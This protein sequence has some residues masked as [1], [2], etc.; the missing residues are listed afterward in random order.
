[1]AR[2]SISVV[3]Q[4][5]QGRLDANPLCLQ[6]FFMARCLRRWL[7]GGTAVLTLAACDAAQRVDTAE[8]VRPPAAG[9]PNEAADV[10]GIYRSLGKAVL[11]LR[12]NGELVLVAPAGGGPD[13]GRFVLRDGRLEVQTTKCGETVGT[14]EMEVT[15]EQEAGKATLQINAVSDACAE[16]RRDL[17]AYPWV[18]ANS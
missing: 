2:S 8:N 16:R 13:S 3:P 18:Y 14:Y 7:A 6:R 10:Q 17:T 12:G 11:Q 9:R 4:G 5:F 15:G 1:M